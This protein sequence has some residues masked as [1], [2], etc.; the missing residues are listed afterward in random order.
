MQTSASRNSPHTRTRTVHWLAT[1]IAL[2]AV[3]GGP[4]LI[5]PDGRHAPSPTLTDDRRRPAAPDPKGPWISRWIAA[6]RR[7]V[8]RRQGSRATSTAT[9]ARRPSQ[10]SAATPAPGP[11]RA[12]SM[13]WPAG[14]GRRRAR[15][16]ATLVDPTEKM[17][18]GALAVRDGVIT[19]TLLG[20]SSPDVPAAARTSRKGEV[21]VAGRQ[22][23]PHRGGSVRR[24]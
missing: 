2:A 17:S 12:A 19:A 3:V 8:R 16:V 10:W 15:V 7:P 11:R 1:A 9:A 24:A 21:A 13:Y 4:A 14:Q 5:Q 6:A 22:V 23:R 20:Y 18:V